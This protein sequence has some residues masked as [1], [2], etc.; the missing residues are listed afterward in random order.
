MCQTRR[1]VTEHLCKPVA[2]PSSA[3]CQCLDNDSP[4][5]LACPR[6]RKTIVV[7]HEAHFADDALARRSCIDIDGPLR[8]A[9]DGSGGS[10]DTAEPE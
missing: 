9:R 7:P 1:T 6:P 3:L 5:K 2:S 10:G 4:K 8:P